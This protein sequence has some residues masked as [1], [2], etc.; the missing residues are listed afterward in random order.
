MS[1]RFLRTREAAAYIGL[2]AQ[3]LNR[4]RHEG[5]PLPFSRLG[6]TVVYDVADLESF[7]SASKVNAS[8]AEDTN[9]PSASRAA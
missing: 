4:W 9:A 8:T 7:V 2:A 6:R 3:T 1:S 5:R